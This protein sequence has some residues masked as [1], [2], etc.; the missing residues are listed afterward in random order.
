M[1]SILTQFL[2]NRS[3]H[4]TVGGCHSK[5]VNVVSGVPQGSVFSPLLCLL[6]TSDL[7]SKLEYKLVGYADDSTLIAV[8][9]SPGVAEF[10]N[11]DLDKVSQWC[12]LCRMKFNASKIMIVPR[13]AH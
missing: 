4:V 6:H 13:Y 1:L 3:L 11:R 10:L 2:S 9:Q 7:F 5:L 12:D 8:V